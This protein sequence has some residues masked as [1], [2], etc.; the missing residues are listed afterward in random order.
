MKIMSIAALLA[1]V[2]ASTA[3]AQ[4]F[5]ATPILPDPQQPTPAQNRAEMRRLTYQPL[6]TRLFQEGLTRRALQQV[7]AERA[8]RADRVAA[9]INSGQC[10]EAITFARA[11]RDVQ[12]ERNARTVC[13]AEVN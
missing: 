3:F 5:P 2:T 12:I 4:Q 1:L 9:L 8:S 6:S 7:S 11:E 10:Q 13:E